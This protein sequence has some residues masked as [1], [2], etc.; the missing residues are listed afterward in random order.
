MWAW[1]VE[2]SETRCGE[3]LFDTITANGCHC[4][5]AKV[6]TKNRAIHG[7]WMGAFFWLGGE[8]TD[9]TLSLNVDG[10][11]QRTIVSH[12][13]DTKHE[14]GDWSFDEESEVIDLVPEGDGNKQQ[15]SVL[16]VTQCERSNTM[17]VLRR[18]AL[19]SRNLPILLYRVHHRPHEK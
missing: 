14:F 16:D 2:G 6:M 19:A 10:T 17:L 9:W 7:D 1:S 12:T 11:F 8:R 15:W 18:V 3:D 4:Y 5:R 13:G